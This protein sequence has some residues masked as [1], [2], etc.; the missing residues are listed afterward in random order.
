MARGVKQKTGLNTDS[1]IGDAVKRARE[2]RKQLEEAGGVEYNKT[3]DLSNE[4]DRNPDPDYQRLDDE[5]FED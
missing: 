2:R 4:L 3:D 5:I 1:S